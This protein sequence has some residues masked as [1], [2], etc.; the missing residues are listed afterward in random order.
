MNPLED[1][2]SLD[3]ST[4]LRWGGLNLDERAFSSKRTH[5]VL[6]LCIGWVPIPI[7]IGIQ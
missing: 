1:A 3:N 7:F 5:C 2:N 6:S 4:H